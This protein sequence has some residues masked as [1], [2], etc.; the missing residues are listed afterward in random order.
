MRAL[1]KEL[2]GVEGRDREG[3]VVEV[4][5]AESEQLQP[6]GSDGEQAGGDRPGDQDQRRAESPQQNTSG[7]RGVPGSGIR[8]PPPATETPVPGH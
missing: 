8:T 7:G 1:Q 5:E 2:Q 4:G 6:G 3:E